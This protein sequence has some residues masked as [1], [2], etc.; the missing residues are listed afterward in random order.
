MKVAYCSSFPTCPSFLCRPSSLYPLTPPPF[1]LPRDLAVPPSPL[2]QM[3]VWLR[4]CTHSWLPLMFLSKARITCPSLH[5]TQPAPPAVP[6]PLLLLQMIVRLR[7]CTRSWLPLSY[8]QSLCGAGELWRYEDWAPAADWD[9][10]QGPRRLSGL[11]PG[12]VGGWWCEGSNLQ[13]FSSYVFLCACVHAAIAA[14]DH[15]VTAAAAV[16]AVL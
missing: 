8:S 6:P 4:V 2:L 9:K 11:P 16:V 12:W 15:S 14:N 13:I 3:I 1:P 5:L 10:T 7:V